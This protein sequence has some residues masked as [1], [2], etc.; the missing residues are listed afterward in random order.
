[1]SRDKLLVMGTAL[2]SLGDVVTK[3]K[4]S[5]CESSDAT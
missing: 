2:V 5:Q 3:V 1:M 4:G